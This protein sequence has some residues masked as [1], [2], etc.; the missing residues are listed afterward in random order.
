MRPTCSL[1]Q[2]SQPF[3]LHHHRPREHFGHTHPTFPTIFSSFCSIEQRKCISRCH[4]LSSS[5]CKTLL[6]I[7]S[8]T[9]QQDLDRSFAFAPSRYICYLSLPAFCGLLLFGCPCV[10]VALANPCTRKE[11]DEARRPHTCSRTCSFED[12]KNEK[13]KNRKKTPTE[14]TQRK[15]YQPS[16]RDHPETAPEKKHPSRS[17]ILARFHR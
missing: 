16:D 12:E 9:F 7:S 11:V 6:R 17:P 8:A 3:F 14:N 5:I 15:P 1:S 2:H 13:V 10:V 4:L